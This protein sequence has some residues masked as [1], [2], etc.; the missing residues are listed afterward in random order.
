MWG[1]NPSKNNSNSKL[2]SLGSYSINGAPVKARNGLLLERFQL[3]K[4]FRIAIKLAHNGFN[5]MDSYD[6]R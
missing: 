5:V 2:Y 6:V 4:I 3:V 1:K